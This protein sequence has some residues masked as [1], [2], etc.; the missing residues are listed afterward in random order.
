M[1]YIRVGAITPPEKGR[2][3]WARDLLTKAMKAKLS[4]EF[5][6]GH[7]VTSFTANLP[8]H[9]ADWIKQISAKTNTSPA[10]TSA[11]LIE[12]ACRDQSAGLDDIKAESDLFAKVAIEIRPMLHAAVDASDKG[13]IAFCEAATGIGKGRAIL[14]MALDSIDKGRNAVISAPLPII[15]DL[16][17]QLREIFPER[18]PTTSFLLGRANFVSPSALAEWAEEAQCEPMLAWIAAGGPP[19]SE[20]AKKLGEVLG[21]TLNWLAEEA[22][23]IADEAAERSVLLTDEADDID[24]CPAEMVY[25]SLRGQTASSQLIFCSHHYLAMNTK[26]IQ[27]SN[28][29]M[30]PEKIGTLL[31]DEAH[32]LEAAFSSIFT[33]TLHVRAFSRVIE[34]CPPK[35]R[36]MAIEAG[37]NFE[38][39]CRRELI[40]SESESV[41]GNLESMPVFRLAAKAL[42][43]SLKLLSPKKG[44]IRG[45]LRLARGKAILN[46]ALSG[47]TTIR[48]SLTPQ[49]E[50][51]LLT[52]GQSNL[53]KP[54]NLMWGQAQG[55]AVFSATLY[56]GGKNQGG[57][58]RWMLGVPLGREKFLPSVMP[59]WVFK[60]VSLKAAK[61]DIKPDDENPQWHEAVAKA[62]I[63]VAEGAKGGT[64]VLCTAYA[65]IAA[66]QTALTPL[67]GDRL[68]CQSRKQGVAAPLNRFMAHPDRPVWI[69]TGSAWTGINLT[70]PNTPKEHPELDLKLTDLVIP[71]FPISG[72]G[73]LA[74]ERRRKIIGIG[75]TI[76][77][78]VWVMKQGIGRLVRR[79]GVVGRNLWILDCRIN[80]RG[81]I[82]ERFS[83]L[84]DKY[85]KC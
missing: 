39:A 8:P 16:S 54:L 73:S 4:P 62:I 21:V 85:H 28:K 56:T 2:A 37:D 69:A 38:R 10:V 13:M 79:R 5:V 70:D 63:D 84:L 31:I 75:A 46:S 12:A 52:T 14:A 33:S 43:E 67:L 48:I 20:R 42:V 51:A 45:K 55:G 25:R 80:E 22:F 71:R 50:Y 83:A 58:A 47:K 81:V 17:E 68:I 26:S 1:D 77:Y 82:G 29:S 64:L 65:T 9:L 53:E 24:S 7:L 59:D 44:D 74:Q 6:P 72:S 35:N 78:G 36:K 23:S 27:T 40:A 11:G 49:R 15:W 34:G 61:I 60:P 41:S 19:L 76:Q 30:L 3:Q 57:L 18:S 66:L 32:L